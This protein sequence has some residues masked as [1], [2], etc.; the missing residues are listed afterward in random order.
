M[1]H[2]AG[3]RDADARRRTM[4]QQ[5]RLERFFESAERRDYFGKMERAY[6]NP[7]GPMAELNAEAVAF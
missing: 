1:D 7:R 5:H 4:L 3:S 6:H 2:E